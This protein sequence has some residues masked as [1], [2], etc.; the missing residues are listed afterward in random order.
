ML[1]LAIKATSSALDKFERKISGQRTVREGKGFSYLISNKDMDDIIKI[2]EWPEK[3]SVLIGGVTKTVKHE[4]KKEVD[5]LGH[6]GTYGWIIDSTYNFLI[7]TTCGFFIDKYH[8]LE[9]ES[10]DQEKYKKVDFFRY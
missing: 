2:V 5:F 3:S 6:N 4:I 9:N 10:R 1:K 7:D 8:I